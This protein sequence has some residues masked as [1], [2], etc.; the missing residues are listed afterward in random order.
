MALALTSAV[1]MASFDSKTTA[2]KGSRKPGPPEAYVMGALEP[3]IAM[4]SGFS[5]SREPE[6]SPQATEQLGCWD[7]EFTR[8]FLIRNRHSL[9][10][11]VCGAKAATTH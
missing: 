7:S 10:V 5:I 2:Q 9:P 4:P 11:R 8:L 1:L 3:L 6:N